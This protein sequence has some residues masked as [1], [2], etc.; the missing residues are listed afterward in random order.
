MAY[1]DSFV[2]EYP[3]LVYSDDPEAVGGAGGDI[4]IA[5]DETASTL[6]N[7]S[8]TNVDDIHIL[9]DAE[10]S[11]TIT[12]FSVPAGGLFVIAP[13]AYVGLT[14]SFYIYAGEL[15]VGSELEPAGTFTV[16]GTDYNTYQLSDPNQ[17]Y[18]IFA[19]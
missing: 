12:V 11:K 3:Y 4:G 2:D 17:D 13:N 18:A 16:E 15:D 8:E 7:D 1:K 14:N 10:G 6:D 5:P 19:K 9:A